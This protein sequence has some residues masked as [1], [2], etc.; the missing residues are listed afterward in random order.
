MLTPFNVHTPASG[1]RI[2]F[3]DDRTREDFNSSVKDEQILEILGYPT[4]SKIQDRENNVILNIGDL[5]TPEAVI[6]AQKADRLE[7]LFNSVYRS[8]KK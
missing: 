1:Y 6:Q 7:M 5:I 2:Q 3:I 8:T 4:K